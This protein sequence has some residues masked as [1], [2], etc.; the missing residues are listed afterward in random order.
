MT[1]ALIGLVQSF[2]LFAVVLLMTGESC[3]LPWPSEVIMT[4]AGAL[5]AAGHLSLGGAIA[6]ATLGNLIGSLIAYFLAARYGESLLLGPGKWVGI[7]PNHLALAKRWFDR[8]GLAAV[9]VGRML[10]VVRTYISFPAGLVGT[11]LK[12]FSILTVI[13]SIPWCAGLAVAGYVLG[14]QYTKVAGPVQEAGLVIA[15]LVVLV[16][17]V[18]FVRGRTTEHGSQRSRP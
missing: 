5:A 8:Y 14:R 2:G 9:L 18:W 17:V 16:L 13:G 11:E 3:G 10:P 4:T 15:L 12:R 7:S 6:A 1:H